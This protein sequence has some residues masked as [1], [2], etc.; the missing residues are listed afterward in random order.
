MCME[1]VG[2]V[3]TAPVAIDVLD[4]PSGHLF[5]LMIVS[6][7]IKMIYSSDE[8][9]G[10]TFNGREEERKNHLHL[11]RDFKFFEKAGSPPAW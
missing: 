11:E 9:N 6:V 7:C 4:A 3:C 10:R 8:K 2:E 5:A 1:N